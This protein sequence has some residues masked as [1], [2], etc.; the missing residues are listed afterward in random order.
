[1]GISKW[2]KRQAAYLSLS[3]MGVEKNALGQNGN[4]LD[5]G[6][7]QERRHTEGTLADSLKQGNITQEVMNLRWRTYKILKA[8]EGVRTEIIGYDVN[9]YPITKT[10]KIDKKRGLN[11][12]VVDAFD[13]YNLEMVLDNTPIVTSGNDMMDNKNINVLET[14]KINYNDEGDVISASHG[15]ITGEEYFATNKGEVPIKITRDITAKFEIENY[16]KKLVVRMMNKNE[17]LLEFYVS[18]YPDEYNR[19]SRLFLS[20]LKKVI[21]N[22]RSSTILDIKKVGF[23]TYKTLGV[24]D[25]LEYQYNIKSFSKIIEFNGH[26][27]IKFIADV[28]VNG[29]D[30]LEEHRVDELDEKYKNKEKRKK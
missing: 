26:Y 28:I 23:I 27:V 15:L 13:K 5:E 9:G 29:V 19:T 20:D 11:K 30:I 25:F 18:K 16:T 21:E 6:V 8:S 2:F 4:K 3:M 17:R 24:Y 10:T 22:Q 7:S 14:A 12:V 1:M